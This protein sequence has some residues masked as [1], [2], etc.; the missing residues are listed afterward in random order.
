[1]KKFLICLIIL[2][3]ALPSYAWFWEKK[4]KALEAELQGKGYAG[5]LPDL[6]TKH[7]PK[8]QKVTT[9]IFESKKDFNDPSD[10]KPVP[11]DDPAFVNIIQKK[12]KTSEYLIDAN[13]I[14]GI[15]EKLLDCIESDGSVQLFCTRANVLSMNL[16]YLQ[17]KYDGQPESYYQSFKKIMELNQYVKSIATLRKEAQVYQRYLAYQATGS[18]YNPENI[19][20][21]LEYLQ[22][23]LKTAILMLK[24]E[25]E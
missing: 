20:Q 6:T 23:E 21:Q 16:D 8:E 24:E 4:D 7:K 19:N 15:M 10:L 18:I 13:E 2:N 14:I 9:P 25:E 3:I 1:M 11:K 17:K 5:T 22:E 12:D